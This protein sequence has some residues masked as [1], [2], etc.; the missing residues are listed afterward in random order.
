MRSIFDLSGRTAVVTGG[1]THVGLA[2]AQALGCFGARVHLVGRRYDTCRTA[3]VNLDRQGVDAVPHACDAADEAAMTA[4]IAEIVA[5]SG[6][7]D[8][9][10]ANAGGCAGREAAPGIPQAQWDG[11][12]RSTVTTAIV[13][14]Q[15]AARTM[16]PVVGGRIIL[17][18]SIHGFLGSDRRV[19]TARMTR[20]ASDY[21]A[22]KGAVINLARSLACELGPVNITVNS[23]SPGHIPQPDASAESV[24]ALGRL[25]P[26][27][28]TGTPEDVGGVA[29]LLASQAGNFITGQNF[30]VDGGLSAW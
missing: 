23:I 7:L 26:L 4:L 5:E 11:T 25:S 13:S 14:A 16:N 29:V 27:G 30:V 6:R 10:V 22:A 17:I 15:V 18:A 24:A 21:H 12:F 28:R 19:Y 8:I 20:S 2:I 1:G 3:A 9:M